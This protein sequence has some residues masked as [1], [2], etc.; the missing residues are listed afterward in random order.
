LLGFEAGPRPSFD[1][2]GVWLYSNG[3]PVLHVIEQDEIPND[4]GVIDHVAFWGTDL[5][6]FL[7]KLK[8]RSIAF[9]LHR[10][11]PGGPGPGVWQL[12]F[13]DPNGVKVEID[14]PA[15]EPALQEA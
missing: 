1:V 9:D 5:P 6:S 3:R 2:A 8:E 12:F 4:N 11:P 15:N 13:Q 7:A 14:L 10:A